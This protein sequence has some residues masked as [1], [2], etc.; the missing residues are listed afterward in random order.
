MRKIELSGAL[1]AVS[2][3]GLGGLSFVYGNFAP[4]LD[5]FPWPKAWTYGLGA[6]L[7]AACGGLF[8]TR[9]VT[10][11]ATIIAAYSI[12]WAMVCVRPISHAPLSVGSWYGFS[13]AMSLL[14]GVWMLYALHWR[15]DHA[16]GTTALLT[17]DRALRVGR[18][19]FGASCLVYGIAH[20]A[21]PAYS[22][23]FVPTWLPAR[24]LLLYL[25]G[26]CHIA[27]GVALIL[28]VL[29]WLAVTLEAIMI[30]LFG[31]LVWLP[32]LF[33]HPVPKWAGSPQ[34]Q[35][36]E[37]LLTFVL[38]AVALLV[39]DSLCATPGRWRGPGKCQR[40]GLAPCQTDALPIARKLELLEHMSE[41]TALFSPTAPADAK[42]AVRKDPLVD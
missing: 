39:A 36:S 42:S 6:L 27:A 1:F 40:V 10:A 8:L 24:M 37:T 26:A 17:S 29:P 38:A 3:A 19:L 32:S 9:T 18:I 22:L 5:P 7:L 14:V 35:W 34:N 13:E 11:S 12:A 28:G 23:P 21:Y 15:L 31:V 2:V 41:T 4:L 25:T 30:I 20:F 33:A 16:A